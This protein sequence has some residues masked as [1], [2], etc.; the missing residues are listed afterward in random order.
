MLDKLEQILK[1][2]W[3]FSPNFLYE[4]K[5]CSRVWNMK[6]NKCYLVIFLIGVSRRVRVFMAVSFSSKWHGR[7]VEKHLCWAQIDFMIQYISYCSAVLKMPEL[8]QRKCWVHWA[9]QRDAVLGHV[10]CITR[11]M[12]LST[13]LRSRGFAS[14]RRHLCSFWFESIV[15][16]AGENLRLSRKRLAVG[17]IAWD[18]GPQKGPLVLLQS[19]HRR[20]YIL[21]HVAGKM[22]RS[23]NSGSEEVSLAA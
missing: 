8:A 5:Y 18:Y 7:A 10:I 16:N 20:Q 21:S 6:Q 13:L 14:P 3:K 17:L 12:Q 11:S 19:H 1:D 15:A 4:S 2:T 23:L 9:Q 22:V